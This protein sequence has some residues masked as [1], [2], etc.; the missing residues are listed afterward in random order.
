LE[1]SP[2]QGLSSHKTLETTVRLG[3][4][5]DPREMNY[6]SA[7]APQEAQLGS[8]R[9]PTSIITLKVRTNLDLIYPPPDRLPANYVTGD[10]SG[11]FVDL[12]R[13]KSAGAGSLT[14]SL[15][16]F[17]H[18]EIF[19]FVSIRPRDSTGRRDEKYRTFSLQACDKRDLRQAGSVQKDGRR[20]AYSG[21]LR[22]ECQ[23]EFLARRSRS[24]CLTRSCLE[25]SL[26][27]EILSAL[28]LMVI[29]GE[30]ISRGENRVCRVRTLG[31]GR[32]GFTTWSRIVCN[33]NSDMRDIILDA[34]NA[35]RWFYCDSVSLYYVGDST[36]C[37]VVV[38]RWYLG[39]MGIGLG[40][41]GGGGM[42]PPGCEI[43]RSGELH[44]SWN[45]YELEEDIIS[46]VEV[47]HVERYTDGVQMGDH[48]E[49]ACPE[50]CDTQWIR[51]VR[52]DVEDSMD[53]RVSRRAMCLNE[54]WSKMSDVGSCRLDGVGGG[55]VCSQQVMVVS[56]W[57][58]QGLSHGV[59]WGVVVIELSLREG[60]DRKEALLWR[61][62]LLGWRL[63]SS[64][65]GSE[66][67]PG[68]SEREGCSG[69]ELH[70]E[71]VILQI[72]ILFRMVYVVDRV[73]KRTE[74]LY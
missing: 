1:E 73:S 67:S 54:Y 52:S 16:T 2:D 48:N 9:S 50:A 60:V 33:N 34:G 24:L 8:R 57:V 12:T 19:I 72:R 17:R 71:A 20:T 18:L 13:G 56:W 35:R 65:R 38:G 26:V 55:C 70:R 59:D 25:Y 37:R 41:R 5:L 28:S 32:S 31:C 74:V 51:R 58:L 49:D 40:I 69:E 23:R 61:G 47:C 6:N 27:G 43:V 10:K 11:F 64:G 36:L 68:A 45:V 15:H 66:I 62:L 53:F 30:K 7:Q 4:E 3:E 42:F 22:I 39:L 21:A 29:N 14:L 63:L 46:N 44:T